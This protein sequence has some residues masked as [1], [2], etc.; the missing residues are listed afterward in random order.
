MVAVVSEGQ[1][2]ASGWQRRE[3]RHEVDVRSAVVRS[4]A[5][6][7]GLGLGSGFGFGFGLGF[8]FGFGFGFGL[9]WVRV[10]VRSGLG[11][12]LGSDA[13]VQLRH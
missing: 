13:T 12:G 8:W 6:C 1:V 5:T 3:E 9:E 2:A 10:R 4:D 7:L 11:L